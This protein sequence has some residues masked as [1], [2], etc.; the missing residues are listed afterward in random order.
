MLSKTSSKKL[1]KWVSDWCELP[2]V[3]EAKRPP[4]QAVTKSVD[5]SKFAR[6][7]CYTVSLGYKVMLIK[8]KKQ[9]IL[10]FFLRVKKSF[11]VPAGMSLRVF[12]L[13]F[14]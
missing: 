14:D 12:F 5:R 11:F 13:I 9:Q 6:N 3:S 1:Q 2:A 8:I 4:P 10:P 7:H